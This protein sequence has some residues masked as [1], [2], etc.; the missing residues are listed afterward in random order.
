M[1]VMIFLTQNNFQTVQEFPT[2]SFDFTPMSA[3]N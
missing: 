1:I 3:H 2:V